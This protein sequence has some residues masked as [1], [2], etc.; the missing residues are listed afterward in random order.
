M[1]WMPDNILGGGERTVKLTS[2][3]TATSTST[4][5]PQELMFQREQGMEEK[6]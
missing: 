3:T 5:Y 1:C 6:R 2:I 4:T